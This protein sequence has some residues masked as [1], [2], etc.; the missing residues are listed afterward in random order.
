[1]T[2]VGEAMAIAKSAGLDLNQIAQAVA[3]SSGGSKVFSSRHRF[4]IDDSFVPQFTCALM[5]KDVALAVD[6]ASDL[7]VATPVASAALR[8]YD[9]ALGN[10]H[11]EQDFAIVAKA[12]IAKNDG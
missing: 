10:G 8:Q 12:G 3:A 2:L 1:M 6:L 4:I 9:A 5:R 7:G 11:A